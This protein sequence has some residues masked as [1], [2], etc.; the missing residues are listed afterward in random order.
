M[1]NLQ[2]PV[3]QNPNF[4]KN[5]KQPSTALLNPLKGQWDI[6]VH[7]AVQELRKPQQN[8]HVRDQ[9]PEKAC[10]LL[11]AERANTAVHTTR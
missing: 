4:I 7:R 2:T 11:A 3:C 10:R 8:Q 1:R 5:Q 6:P 9:A